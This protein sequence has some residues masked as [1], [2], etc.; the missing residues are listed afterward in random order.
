[1]TFDLETGTTG[2]VGK[3]QEVISEAADNEE[4]DKE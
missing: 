3:Q 2:V 1:L 4:E